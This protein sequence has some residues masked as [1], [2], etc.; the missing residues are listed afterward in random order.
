MASDRPQ[1]LI[2]KIYRV[3]YGGVLT[4]MS[5]DKKLQTDAYGTQLITDCLAALWDALTA[6]EIAKDRI[7]SL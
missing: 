4:V 2:S 5:N 6:D 3:R 1:R 7:G